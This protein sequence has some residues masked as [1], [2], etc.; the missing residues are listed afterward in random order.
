MAYGSVMHVRCGGLMVHVLFCRANMMT[1]AEARRFVASSAA[2]PSGIVAPLWH[3]WLLVAPLRQ[4]ASS[5]THA[6]NSIPTLHLIHA[7]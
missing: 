7:W 1:D 5:Y 3:T 4:L 2:R 6:C